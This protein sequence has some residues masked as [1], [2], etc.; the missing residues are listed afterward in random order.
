MIPCGLFLDHHRLPRRIQPRQQ[1]CRFHLCGWHFHFI[2]HRNRI[3]RANNRHRQPPAN[4]AIG[5][6]SEQPDRPCDPPHRTAAQTGIP[7]ECRG[8]RTG[9]HC[10]HNQTHTGARIATINHIV[11]LGKPANPDPEHRPFTATMFDHIRAKGA[12]RPRRVQHIVALQQS[13]DL[14]LAHRQRT[15]NQRPVRNRL[16]ARHLGHTH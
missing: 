5:L 7:R 10:A 13:G 1:H 4:T 3:G 12:H 11:R 9:R 15:Q 14:G 2:A 16:V 8:N 6:H